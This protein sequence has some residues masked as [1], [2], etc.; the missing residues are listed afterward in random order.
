MSLR[1]SILLILM[2]SGAAAEERCTSEETPRQ[3]LRQLVETHAYETAQAQLQKVTTAPSVTSSPVRT[4]LKDFLSAAAAHVEG[5]TVKESG[6][7]LTFDYNLP[8]LRPQVNFQVTLPDPALSPAVNA[9]VANNAAAKALL[10]DALSRGD[11][12]TGS[13]SFNAVNRWFG[14]SLRPHRALFDSML[15]ALAG[16]AASI[17]PSVPAASLDTPFVQLFPDPAARITAMAEFEAASIAA[18]PQAAAR[19]SDDLTRLAG[20]QPQL[21]ATVQYHHRKPSI[22]ARERAYRLTWEIGS[23]NLNA[24]RRGGGRDCEPAGTCLAAFSDYASRTARRHRS[25]RVSLAIEYRDTDDNDPGLTAPPVIE[26]GSHKLTYSVAYGQ[27]I[28]SLFGA[29]RGRIDWTLNFDG[30]HSTRNI[31]ATPQS[32]APAASLTIG[33]TTQFLP[34]SSTR[35]FAVMLTQPLWRGVTLPL[36][37]VRVERKLW[38]PGTLPALTISPPPPAGADTH[39]RPYPTN[40]RTIEVLI[41]IRWVLPSFTPRNAP[42]PKECCCR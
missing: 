19:I 38:L 8:V 6:Q 24:F 4:P 2:A 25:G 12:V 13:I 14:L 23:D 26:R 40:E 42:K 31:T 18:L 1:I 5:S 27:E 41:G 10:R 16:T 9:E 22:G 28:P 35:S 29:P 39:T 30:A 33:P 20:N 21:F 3:C 15:Y 7:A 32:R 11:D 17:T 34:P 36:S 37:V